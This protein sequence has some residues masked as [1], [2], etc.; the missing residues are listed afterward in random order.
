MKSF[1]VFALLLLLPL[2]ARAQ[3]SAPVE[4]SAAHSLEWDR[5]AK[6]YTAREK[7]HAR[8]G[9]LEVAGDILVAHY[10]D[11]G[12]ATEIV[13]LT[14]TGTVILSSPPYRAFGNKAVYETRRA[15]AVLTG[16]DL[17]IETPREKLSAKDRI[18]FFETENRLTATGDAFAVQDGNTLR[19]D[20]IS[21]FFREDAEG[22][23]A[24]ERMKA[25][26]GVIITTPKEKV[27]GDHGVYDVAGKQAVLTG[28][29]KIFQGENWLEGTRAEVDLKT[30]ISKL[31]A[32]DNPA[33]E[34][35][36]KGVFYP[37]ESGK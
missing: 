34:G 26:G 25:D 18:E 13:R 14:A 21:G 32:G 29:V 27:H 28:A 8:Q 1:F 12:G 37:K 36:V 22:N 17:R 5:A 4:I 35:R 9:K 20:V 31:F 15:H 2:V 19:A 30:G 7:A 10:A 33:T 23:L 11:E 24:L 16:R 3:S 6:T